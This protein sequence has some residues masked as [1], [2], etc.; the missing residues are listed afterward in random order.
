LGTPITHFCLRIGKKKKKTRTD[1]EEKNGE[2]EETHINNDNNDKTFEFFL[3][4][5]NYKCNLETQ[6]F[7]TILHLN[8]IHI[9]WLGKMPC[10]NVTPSPTPFKSYAHLQILQI[11]I[12]KVIEFYFIFSISG[13]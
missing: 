2:G 3:F 4:F 12:V 13:I 6:I 8:P 7:P 11:N 1:N 5:L 10:F 9:I